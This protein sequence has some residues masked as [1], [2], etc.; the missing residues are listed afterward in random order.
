MWYGLNWIILFIHITVLWLRNFALIKTKEGYVCVFILVA[1]CVFILGPVDM[2]MIVLL[3][4]DSFLCNCWRHDPSPPPEHTHILHTHAHRNILA[5]TPYHSSWAAAPIQNLTHPKGLYWH[6]SIHYFLF[7][8][9][10]ANAIPFCL[11]PLWDSS[12][13]KN[14]PPFPSG[15]PTAP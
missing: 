11:K 5:R 9:D 6:G 13:V 4:F 15:C 7:R 1:L 10:W 3:D 8:M 2:T 14:K 12:S